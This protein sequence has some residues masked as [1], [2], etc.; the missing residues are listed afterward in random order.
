[1]ENLNIHN[2]F[3]H[4]GNYGNLLPLKKYFV[5]TLTI[6]SLSVHAVQLILKPYFGRV[7]FKGGFKK[8]A[9]TITKFEKCNLKYIKIT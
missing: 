1:M 9:G 6:K 8:R 2:V 5:K 7:Q 3:A 4:C